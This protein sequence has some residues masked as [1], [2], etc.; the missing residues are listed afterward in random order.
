MRK[1]K[2]LWKLLFGRTTL[3][4]LLILFQVAVL[5]G[6]FAILDQYVFIF[7]YLLG[8]VS[9]I[10]LLYILNARQ[11]A[12]FKLT[13]IM[14]ILF[15]PFFGVIFYLYTRVQPG[16]RFIAS[17]IREEL[18]LQAPYLAQDMEICKRLEQESP[19]AA[20]LSRY[21][22]DSGCYP[23]YDRTHVTYFPS[24]EDKFREM[25]RQLEQAKEFIFM[26]YFI[27][28]K[29]FMWGTILEILARKARQGVEV[30]F[31]Y[32][33]TCSLSLLPPNY[34]QRLEDMG[35]QC[36]VFAPIIP[37]LSTHQNNRDH[38]KVLVIDG[39]TA[40]TGGINLADE[41]IN[42]IERFGH[43]KD[44]AVM[45]K[46]NAVRSFTLMFLQMWNVRQ[47]E[48]SPIEPYMRYEFPQQA[49][50][51]EREKSLRK[52]ETAERDRTEKDDAGYVIPYGDSP[53]D[54]EYVGERVYSDILYQ[55]KS[56]VHIMTP[57]LILDDE[58]VTALTYAVKRGVEVI[59][60]M[61][62]IPDKIYAYLLART[63]YPELIDAGVQI[64]EYTPG[65]VHA[66]VFTSDDE[67][68]V[69]GTIN[70]DFRSLYL[71]FE[72]AVYIYRNPVVRDVEGDFQDTL[73][74][75]QKITIEDCRE[76][77]LFK[78][79]AGRILR[80]VAPLM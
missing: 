30:R 54:T 9:L 5:V 22:H 59:I 77:N 56:Y 19:A 26:E 18:E 47:T 37:F 43:W 2:G 65:F 15:M 28:D 62:H 61:P 58:M 35:I 20:G 52:D 7:N 66:K 1:L 80:L 23:T 44:T 41:Y 55:A 10:V 71:H 72:D 27:V 57:Y 68:A 13:W 76:Y 73:K 34:G 24:G 50:V 6:G 69:V 46:G 40:F 74:K 14:L 12:S 39:H 60:I 42:E 16:T 36:R 51:P 21:I 31:M 8:F 78:K 38:R 29:G 70:L 63:Y 45:V 17:R 48:P 4:A 75:C 64:Y 33:G 79:L 3:I 25:V 67:K 49:E 11:N 32:D 53:Y